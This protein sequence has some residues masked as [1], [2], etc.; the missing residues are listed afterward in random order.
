MQ[1]TQQVSCI[2]TCSSCIYMYLVRLMTI[3]SFPYSA[4]VDRF[5]FIEFGSCHEVDWHIEQHNNMLVNGRSISLENSGEANA[6][7]RHAALQS[8]KKYVPP[9]DR[10]SYPTS[11]YLT[12]SH[13]TLSY[14]TSIVSFIHH[15]R[16][17]LL[18]L[19]L[20]FPCNIPSTYGNQWREVYSK[21]ENLMT[22]MVL[23]D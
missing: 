22:V 3:F 1:S 11:S 19:M 5:G 9:P 14:S 6:S 18:R 10:T 2:V 20:K 8:A 21:L 13:F 15:R 17:I 23:G 16:P 4:S 7:H 12:S